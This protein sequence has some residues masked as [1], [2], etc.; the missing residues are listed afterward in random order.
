MDEDFPNFDDF[1]SSFEEQND[2]NTSTDNNFSDFSNFFNPDAIDS[3]TD[4]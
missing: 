4:F 1:C 3:C 2:N